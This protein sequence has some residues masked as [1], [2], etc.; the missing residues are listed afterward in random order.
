[1]L[2]EVKHISRR[3][4]RTQEQLLEG[5]SLTVAGGE[6]IALRGRSGSGKSLLLRAIALLD[7]VDQG[8]VTWRVENLAGSVVPE[9]QI[10]RASCRERV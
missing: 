2:L 3:D 4:R 8:A 10:G 6:R 7:P 1:M 5:I 9:F